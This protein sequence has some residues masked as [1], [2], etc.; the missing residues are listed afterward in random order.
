[1]NDRSQWAKL[2]I[3]WI[4]EGGLTKFTDR[5]IRKVPLGG[6]LMSSIEVDAEVDVEALRNECIAALR[7]YLVLCC[8]ADFK[9][10]LA[11]VT[12][13]QLTLLAKMSRALISRSLKRL[14]GE[15]LIERQP[16]ASKSGTTVRIEGWNDKYGWGKIPKL[17]LHDGGSERMLLLAEFNYCKASL[18]ALK[19]FIAILSHRDRTR[20]GIATL[21]YDKLSIITGVPRYRVADAITKLYDM[22]LVSFRQGDYRDLSPMDRTNRYLV[23][24]LGSYWPVEDA[25]EEP[26]AASAPATPSKPP[27]TAVKTAI[28]F[29]DVDDQP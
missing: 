23:R 3:R 12:Y 14:E 26:L 16:Q 13:P 25:A 15:R 24:G 28:D 8:R 18:D 10:G 21:S 27:K 19:V 5:A 6:P 1:M 29:M 11:E 17:W 9:T 4:H 7:L 2:P 22:E 20:A